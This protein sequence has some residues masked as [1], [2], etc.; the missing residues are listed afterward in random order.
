MPRPP[1]Q[2]ELTVE[3][4]TPDM[5]R[6]WLE[7][8][9]HNRRMSDRLVMV[10]AQA[11]KEGEWK[12]NGEPII[13]DKKGRLQSGQHRLQA[14]V[15]S[16]TPIWS[17]VVRG[18]EAEAIY[19]L[20]SGRRRRMTD[21]LT[22]RGEKDVANLGSAVTWWWRYTVGAMDRLGES[23]TTTH[24]LKVLDE[25]PSIRESLTQG[26]RLHQS[27]GF[28][29][30]LMTA[31]YMAFVDRD[32]DDADF[33]VEQLATQVNLDLTDPAYALV[34]WARNASRE[35]RTPSQVTVAAVTVKAWNAFRE[36]RVIRSLTFKG[37]EEFP[38]VV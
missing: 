20:D 35:T 33:F 7:H 18:A 2:L 14:V 34:R 31:L 5:A 6:D 37:N 28:S 38:E 27:L 26:R 11:M 1:I 10:Y 19:S 16:D 32:Q 3:Y 17:V 21:V 24:L 13:F 25:T 8:N 29:T 12:L 22:L 36:H 4:I 9:T 30:G 23:A 15:E